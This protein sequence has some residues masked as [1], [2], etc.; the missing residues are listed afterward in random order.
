MLAEIDRVLE[1]GGIL[2][3]AP[4]WFCRPWAA[5]NLAGRSYRDL[6]WRDRIVK[7]SIP[8]RESTLWRG[9]TIV[10]H[11]LLAEIRCRLGGRPMSFRYRRLTPNLKQYLTSDSDAFVSMDPH[12]AL[13]YFISR[14]YVV[15]DGRR[16]FRLFVRHAPVILRKKG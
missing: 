15:L 4:A 1:P 7:A 9:C 6:E 8:L 5:K 12:A 3:L 13:L 10:P 11:R 2:Y 14:G 16:R